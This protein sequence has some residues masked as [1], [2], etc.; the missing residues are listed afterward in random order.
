MRILVTGGCGYKGHALVPKLL[1]KGHKVR[2]LDTEWFGNFHKKHPQLETIVGDVNV[3]TSFKL[4]DIDAIGEVV[5]EAGALLIVDAVSSW[6][7][8]QT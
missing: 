6:A 8:M 5:A 7:G 2:V 4:N 3:P 1:A